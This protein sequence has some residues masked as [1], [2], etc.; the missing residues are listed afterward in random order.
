MLTDIYYIPNLKAN[1]IS[2]GQA[3][4]SGCEVS[5]KGDYLFLHD[6]RKALLF[7]VK[8]SLNRLYKTRI[9]VGKL[10][11]LHGRLNDPGCLWH[12]RLRHASFDT[13]ALMSKKNLVSGLPSIT[14]NNQL[15]ES[16]LVGKQARKPFPKQTPYR[17]SKKLE[18]IHG[19]LCGR[20]SPFTIGGNRYIFVLIDGFSRF[21]WC[22][23]MKEKSDAIHCFKKFKARVENETGNCVKVFRTDRGGEFTS[24]DFETLCVNKGIIRHLTSPYTPQ[25]NGV[26]ER[27]NCSLLKMTRSILKAKQIPNYFWGEVVQHA[28]YIINRIPTRALK[29]S[30]P[31]EFYYNRKPNI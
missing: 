23:L 17:A 6:S 25:Q 24:R 31:Y 18:L 7:K 9:L 2:L 27:R 12:A 16:C 21:M 26:E 11:C 15:C 30:T 4:E 28:T 13:I 19:D 22:F 1:I 3:T 5:M 29:E 14:E 10:I 20:I 8:R